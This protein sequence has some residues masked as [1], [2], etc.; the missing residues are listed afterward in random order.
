M[1]IPLNGSVRLPLVI[2]AI[3]T[4]L[5]VAASDSPSRSTET[6]PI[7]NPPAVAAPSAAPVAPEPAVT[8]PPLAPGAP[9]AVSCQASPRSG[10]APLRVEFSAA[11]SSGA[12][13]VAYEWSF[14]DGQS[15]GNRSPAYVYA[16]PGTFIASVRATSG[17]ET[18]TCTREISVTAPAPVPGPAPTPGAT[19]TPA[20]IPSPSP[21]ASP[22]PSSSPSPIPSPTPIPTPTPAPLRV[23]TI[24]GDPY[25][26][27]PGS[28]WTTPAGINCTFPPW[29]NRCSAAFP[30]GSVVT[31][32]ARNMIPLGI[33]TIS[34]ACSAGGFDG[35]AQCNVTMSADLEVRVFFFRSSAA[36]LE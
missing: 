13:D 29:S 12:D 9:L 15:T 23:L 32:T 3:V 19:P 6:P 18:A 21:N 20:P 7:A 16:M 4:A 33:T 26:N 34:G 5:A 28:A 2:G 22:S 14:G 31:V 8:P 24:A 25:S 10:A 11:A 1:G 35:Y 17:A 30:H 27:F 36:P